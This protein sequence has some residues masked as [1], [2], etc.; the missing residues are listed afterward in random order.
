MTI[1]KQGKKQLEIVWKDGH[2]SIYSF[3]YLRQRCCCAGCVEEWTGKPILQPEG[4]ALDLEGLSVMPIGNYALGFSFSD[5][6]DTGIYNFEHLRKI[7]PC[8]QCRSGEEE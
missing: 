4:V 7:C 5:H 1:K 2:V 8:Q 3:R 6:H